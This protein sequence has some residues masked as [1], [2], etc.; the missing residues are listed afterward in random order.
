MV[1]MV[2]A[3]IA[4]PDLVRKTMEGR[5]DEVRPCIACN[6][7]C[8]ANINKGGLLPFLS[9]GCAVNPY[10]GKEAKLSMPGQTNEPKKVVVVGGGPAGMEAARV[11]A[12]KGHRVVLFEAAK[13]LGGQLNMAKRA[14]FLHTIGDIADWL[15]RDL[16]R[17]GV[18]VRLSSYVEADEI[19]AEEPDAVIV[20]TGSFP[21][22]DGVSLKEPSLPASGTDQAHVYSSHE[23][24]MNP[25]DSVAGTVVVADDVG[26]YEAIAVAEFL[27]ARG[28][29]IVFASR[30]SSFAPE[31]AFTFRAEPAVKRLVKGGRFRMLTNSYVKSISNRD[32]T[33]MVDHGSRSETIVAEMV[34]LVS[35]NRPEDHLYA[36]LEG[37]VEQL[38]VVGDANSPRY[39]E[40]AIREGHI[41]AKSI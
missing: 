34:V 8:A 7:V 18:D 19:L 20:A 33:V 16:Y 36:E 14:P 40:G 5:E 28:A 4:D 13:D 22:K 23:I 35:H 39:V 2:R 27:Q 21:R 31:M 32:V 26:H 17:R 3:T 1:S 9:I 25:P 30:H 6:Q 24:L 15:E 41:A 12:L 10:A 37:R 11:A 38:Y 29:E